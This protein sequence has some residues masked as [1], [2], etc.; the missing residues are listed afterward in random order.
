MP[1]PRPSLLTIMQPEAERS[2]E[3]GDWICRTWNL[4]DQKTSKPGI[5]RNGFWRTKSQGWILTD[6]EC[7]RP[8][9]V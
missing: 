8:E 4:K 1:T 7:D 2:T 6:R 3:W 5:W 9:S